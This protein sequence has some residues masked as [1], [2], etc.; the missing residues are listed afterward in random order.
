MWYS[1]GTITAANGQTAVTGEGT[2]F[3]AHI[4]RGDGLVVA[5]GTT[6]YEDPNVASN[7]QPTIHP[8]FSD[9]SSASAQFTVVP[10]LG[11]DKDLSGAFNRIRL[12]LED[13]PD[14]LQDLQEGG[15]GNVEGGSE[16]AW[17]EKEW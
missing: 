4:R 16:P 15:N 6:L 9:E 7:S 3:L 12:E 17:A 11:H 8:A 14:I 5:G 13:Y 10:I 2:E 1:Q